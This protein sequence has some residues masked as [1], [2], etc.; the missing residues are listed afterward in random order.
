MI[1]EELKYT[2]EHEWARID[3]DV[4]TIGITDHAQQELGDIT[5]VEVP[6]VDGSLKQNEVFGTIESVKAASDL[7]APLSGK[8]TEVNPD[9]EESP[10][11]INESPYEKGWILKIK[12]SDKS[13]E[14]AL[15]SAADYKS[16][17]EAESE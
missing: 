16:V 2:S 6:E 4:A 8:I 3:G 10:E 14:D 13:E 5:F 15:L 9:L 1:P 17:V 7:Y 12:M 11:V